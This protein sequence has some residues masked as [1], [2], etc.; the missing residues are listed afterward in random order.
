MEELSLSKKTQEALNNPV[1]PNSEYLGKLHIPIGTSAILYWKD[2]CKY[3]QKHL[4]SIDLVINEDI[5]GINKFLL[6]NGTTDIIPIAG[7]CFIAAE[8]GNLKIV[9]ML[10]PYLDND[11]SYVNQCRASAALNSHLELVRIITEKFRPKFCSSLLYNAASSNSLDI[12][13]YLTSVYPVELSKYEIVQK[14]LKTAIHHK[15]ENAIHILNDMLTHL[16]QPAIEIVDYQRI[17]IDDDP[18][19]K[20]FINESINTHKRQLAEEKKIKEKMELQKS[21]DLEQ[22]LIQKNFEMAKLAVSKDVIE[23]LSD[24]LIS[25]NSLDDEE[26]EKEEEDEDIE[27]HSLDTL[28]R[29]A[30]SI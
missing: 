29:S 27:S 7:M 24:E 19:I 23:H 11:I 15:N 8:I 25:D 9:E 22:E 26:Y 14:T 20:K 10:L 12:I 2:R 30:E 18:T 5:E 28:N 3:S 13:H 17:L 4:H 16:P 1:Y 21:I 6:E